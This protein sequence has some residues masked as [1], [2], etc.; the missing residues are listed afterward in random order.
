MSDTKER[1]L[2]DLGPGDEVT[3]FLG[4]SRF[5]TEKIT[6]VTAT[7]IVIGERRFYRV[8]KKNWHQA[9]T[10]IGDGSYHILIGAAAE[11]RKAAIALRIA[12]REASNKFYGRMRSAQ[13][14]LDGIRAIEAAC[15]EARPFLIETGEWKDE[16]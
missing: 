9:G 7:Q 13:F 6:R 3:M 15:A 16:P 12:Y 2:A 14:T 10:E 4:Q 11:K 8:R 5:T 1:T